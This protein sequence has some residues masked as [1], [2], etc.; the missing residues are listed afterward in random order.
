MS[1]NVGSLTGKL[2]ELARRLKNRKIN[3]GFLQD[4]VNKMREPSDVE[5]ALVVQ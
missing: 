5:P 2:E 3:V 4:I 1:W